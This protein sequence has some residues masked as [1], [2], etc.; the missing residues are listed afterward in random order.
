MADPVAASPKSLLP[1]HLAMLR[2]ESGLPDE[3]IAERGYYSA[4]THRELRAL[5]FSERQANAP[6]LVVP[7]HGGDGE[8][9]GYQ[10]R[11]DQPRQ[12]E[13]G[14]AVK[15]ETPRNS[16]P[17]LD[18]PP[19]C[20]DRMRDPTVPLY[21]TEGSKK[22]DALAAA[23]QV[24]ISLSGVAN[25][26]GKNE[27]GGTTALA[28]WN[29]VPL[30]ERLIRI[31]FDSD[32]SRKREVAF[33]MA[34]LKD[35]L[36]RKSAV[37]EI[38]HLPDTADG[39]KQG[40]D[41]FLA[42][43]GTIEQLQQFT[44]TKVEL[45]PDEERLRPE[46]IVSER[47]LREISQDCWDVIIATNE[48]KVFAFQR[49]GVLVRI[50]G[51]SGQP[52]IRPFSES[53]VNFFLVRNADFMKWVRQDGD[54][55]RKPARPGK[56]VL[57]DI[58]TAWAKP[59][60]RLKGVVQTPV[61]SGEGAIT[62]E[63]GY[64]PETELYYDAS[65]R[66]VPAVPP[67]PS[68]TDVR[69]ALGL[70]DEW[71]H[72]FPFVDASSRAHMVAIPLTYIARELIHGPTPLFV[73]AAPTQGTGKGLLAQ[74]AGIMML[75][76]V[77]SVTTEA[78]DG[79]E[80]RKRITAQLIEGAGLVLI[81]NVKRRLDSG[82][83]AAVLT[84]EKWTDRILGKSETIHVPN[85]AVW[86]ATGNNIQLDGEIARRSVSI[87]IDSRRDRPWEG[88]EFLHPNLLE[89]VAENR[90]DLVWSFLVLVRHWFATGASPFSGSLLGTFESWSRV[91][92]GILDAVGIEGFLD[93]RE[94]LYEQA[95]AETEEWRQF[96][97][98]WAEA[99]GTAAVKAADLVELIHEHDLMESFVGASRGEPTAKS[100]KIRL[101][102][103]LRQRAERRYG[104]W[105]IRAAGQ[106]GHQK[107]KL[108]RLEDAE[109][110]GEDLQPSAHPPQP[111][112]SFSDSV[113]ESAEDA[114]GVSRP[115][116]QDTDLDPDWDL[117]IDW[118]AGGEPDNP[119]HSPHPP[120]PDSE[121]GPVNAEGYPKQAPD[122]PPDSPRD[123]AIR[124]PPFCPG[125]RRQMSVV[126]PHELCASCRLQPGG[127]A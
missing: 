91:V 127:S 88:R 103:A 87:R 1:H 23:G 96:I 51:A 116:A 26:R 60:P 97:A 43:G 8:L 25:W 98:A 20:L 13:N 67:V 46:I 76:S 48:R 113:A 22:A 120:Q 104:R 114:E 27:H 34:R 9:A 77:P 70:I 44:R 7:L 100:L 50:D 121:Q 89:W 19:R 65:G 52:R 106:D 38:V 86:I 45:P 93:N 105:F 37:V 58:L 63:P 84:S 92:G 21:V 41:D 82:E 14:K 110:E 47:H 109:G 95:D 90:P 68:E 61:V 5:G 101:G 17:V 115:R 12:G 31:V 117:E 56:D 118:D 111:M 72:D 3:I 74:T 124:K 69:R 75:G 36:E 112:G 30:N 81:D 107:G 62:I 29:F 33:Q 108:Y 99:H 10:I 16:R 119:P 32:V 6:A 18:V 40:I 55:I 28:D 83:L 24:A 39:R 78:R 4:L 11:P 35:F 102:K 85:R 126:R 2:D 66:P 94:Q 125:C 80:W 42:A 57:S 64:Q 49:D 54:M 15:Y 123:D 73:I 71:L 53:D 79:E 122:P 59:V